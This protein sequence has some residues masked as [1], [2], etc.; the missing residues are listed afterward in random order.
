MQPAG[1]LPKGSA[2]CYVLLD[3]LWGAAVGVLSHPL[4]TALTSDNLRASRASSLRKPSNVS[5]PHA[6]RYHNPQTQHVVS[7]MPGQEGC[8]GPLIRIFL[9]AVTPSG[10]SETYD[11]E[12][13]VTTNFGD[14]SGLIVRVAAKRYPS[15]EWTSFDCI[16][17]S[18]KS[19][20]SRDDSCEWVCSDPVTRGMQNARRNYLAWYEIKVCST[21]DKRSE[22]FKVAEDT[23]EYISFY[24]T[25]IAVSPDKDRP[26]YHLYPDKYN[27]DPDFCHG[28]FDQ[29][30]HP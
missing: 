12:F 10:L 17:P 20:S 1:G 25:I 26:Q 2:V 11:H 27:D 6:C 18:D 22:S 29:M 16:G 13:S 24:G 15:D 28:S 23:P 5:S 14:S 4:L 19:K 30:E 3:L 9:S 8:T 7:Y 21:S